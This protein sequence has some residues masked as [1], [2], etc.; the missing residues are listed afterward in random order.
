MVSEESFLIKDFPWKD[1]DINYI[2]AT[3]VTEWE[4]FYPNLD[5]YKV[6]PF[7]EAADFYLLFGLLN[8]SFLRWT[9]IKIPPLSE[10]LVAGRK[11]GLSAEDLVRRNQFVVELETQGCTPALIEQEDLASHLFVE[12]VERVDKVF[13]EYVALAC[14]G[15]I[16]HHPSCTE[17][18]F[19]TERRVAWCAWPSIV[20][21]YGVEAYTTMAEL[22]RD[23]GETN[24]FGGELWAIAAEL[25]RDRLMW[26]LGPSR[27]LTKQLFIDRVFTLQHNGGTFLNKVDWV[28][29][30]YYR[31]VNFGIGMMPTTLLDYQASNP[32]DISKI[33]THASNPV[34]ELVKTTLEIGQDHDLQTLVQWTDPAIEYDD[35]TWTYPLDQY[36]ED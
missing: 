15:E 20:E 13:V 35:P 36:N 12:L 3:N 14:G 11:L 29:K 30:R 26:K 8:K 18:N 25:L 10:A 31:S 24:C 21:T 16:R 5:H 28:N 33:F 34:Q 9:K 1:A 2:C 7:Q 22:F 32:P 4:T 19:T 6:D 23:F 17:D 27:F